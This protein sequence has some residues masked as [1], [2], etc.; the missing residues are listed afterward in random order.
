MT[1]NG[2]IKFFEEL[3]RI[4]YGNLILFA[5]SFVY[6]KDTAEDLVQEAFLHLWDSPPN[7]NESLKSYLYAAV[8]NKCLNHLRHLQVEDKYR[9]KEMEALQI[10]ETY[11]ML[12]DEALIEKIKLAV[13]GLPEKC[14]LSFKMC[15]FQDMKYKE[16]AEE[17]GVSL[18]TVK[19]HMKRA[20]RFLKQYNFDEFLKFIPFF[21]VV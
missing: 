21:F 7:E 3:Y 11:D 17:L 5:Q 8:R 6:Q 15:V 4:Y 14:K 1:K 19:D 9:K 18:D 13:E 20:Y 2:R 10:S 12:H 16:V